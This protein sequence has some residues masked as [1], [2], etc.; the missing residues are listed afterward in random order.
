MKFLTTKTRLVGA[1]FPT[2][3]IE[4]GPCMK[5]LQATKVQWNAKMCGFWTS[6]FSQTFKQ[7][8][9]TWKFYHNN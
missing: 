7:L 2:K 3:M 5:K 1:T 4:N 6:N 9:L 8:G